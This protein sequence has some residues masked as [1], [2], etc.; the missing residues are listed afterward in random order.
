MNNIQE[1]IN[2]NR[3]LIER[4]VHSILPLEFIRFHTNKLSEKNKELIKQLKNDK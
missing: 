2:K 4:L 3:D 1:K